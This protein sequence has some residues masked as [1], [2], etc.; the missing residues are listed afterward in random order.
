MRNIRK[1]E[2]Y[3]E[4]LAAQ[5][6]VSGSGQYVEDIVPGFAYVK[7]L[8]EA[9]KEYTFYNKGVEPV[10]GDGYAF[11]DIVYYVEGQEKLQKCYWSAFTPDMGEKVGLIVV[12]S[13]L[14]PDGNARMIPFGFVSQEQQDQPQLPAMASNPNAKGGDLVLG[15]DDTTNVKRYVPIEAGWM[16]NLFDENQSF[17]NTVPGFY[18]EGKNSDE[19]GGGGITKA[20][21]PGSEG[22]ETNYK[23]A[24]PIGDVMYSSDVHNEHGTPNPYTD[25]ESYAVGGSYPLHDGDAAIS[26]FLGNSLDRQDP[27]YLYPTLAGGSI[28]PIE[29]IKSDILGSDIIGGTNWNAFSDFSGYTWTYGCPPVGGGIES[30]NPGDGNVLKSNNPVGPVVGAFFP[31]NY[32]K[33]FSTDG[34]EEGDW[35]LPSMGEMAFVAARLNTIV[36]TI[37]FYL[38]QQ[39]VLNPILDNLS[40]AGF[41]DFAAFTSTVG[42]YSSSVEMAAATTL[43]GASIAGSN[44]TPPTYPVVM[45]KDTPKGGTSDV[46]FSPNTDNLSAYV[47]PFAMIKDGE[48]QHSLGDYTE[49]NGHQIKDI[50]NGTR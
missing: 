8:Y 11:G 35:Y 45:R 23:Y 13:N 7:E 39:G 20:S 18:L 3:N 22:E 19:E 32:A 29:P 14:A 40:L 46:T 44:T 9:G 37:M 28:E 43:L 38:Y 30:T 49:E 27:A 6:A 16:N 42:T 48:I 34:T 4:F 26:P 10:P 47:L 15:A 31:H 25:G 5:E 33:M 21:V 1:F 41:G 17:F 12:P 50:V 36:N 2:T 24:A